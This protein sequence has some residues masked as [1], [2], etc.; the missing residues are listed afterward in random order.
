M[1][2]VCILSDLWTVSNVLAD[3]K[4]KAMVSTTMLEIASLAEDLGYPMPPTLV[5]ASM[6]TSATLADGYKA[7]MVVD[8]EEGRPME[9]EVILANPIKIAEKRNLT[10]VIPTWYQLYKD[11]MQFLADRQAQK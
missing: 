9:V 4:Y 10:H 6:K 7:S 1:N 5:Q 3:A 11:L 2:P 8:L